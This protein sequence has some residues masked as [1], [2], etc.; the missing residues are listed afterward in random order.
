MKTLKFIPLG[1]CGEIGMNMAVL[2]VDDCNYFIDGGGLFPDASLPGVDLIIPETDWLRKNR[3]KPTAWLITHAHE[4][5]IGALPH[6]Y[7]EFPAPLYST[8][9][10]L[11]MIRS[12]FTEANI[13]GAS[14]QTW[15]VFNSKTIRNITVTPYTVNHS[16]PAST[17]LFIET[18]HGNILHT[19]DFRIDKNP[20]EGSLSHENMK[21]V[22]GQK[23]VRA[24]MSDS[25]NSFSK[26]TDLSEGDLGDNFDLIMRHT[27][28]AVVVTAF[29]SN[30]W[31][32]GTIV[33][34]AKKHDRKIFLLGRSM[35]KNF[36]ISQR[37]KIFDVRPDDVIGDDMLSR[38]PKNRLCIVCTG[39][40]G[41]GFSGASRLATDSIGQFKLEHGDTFVFS[42]R[43]I[44]GNE[45]S[46]GLLTNLIY[47]TG[48]NVVTPKDFNVHVSGH[49]FAED[50]KTCIQTVRPECFIPVHGEFRHLMRHRELAIECG[51]TE[52]NAYLVENG[53]V[54]VLGPQPQ[55]VTDRVRSG[56]EYISQGGRMSSD[57]EI[58]KTRMAL[59]KS[60]LMCVSFIIKKKAWEL[61]CEPN[62]IN[63]GVP[64]K[65]DVFRKK[66]RSV[67]ERSYAKASQRKDFKESML[68]EELR[69]QTR[70][71]L[72]NMV[73]Y[74]CN[75]AVLLQRV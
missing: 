34:T 44:P 42:A 37:L 24:M 13:R 47:R 41:E 69:I 53:D 70:Q 20:P 2:Q 68:E 9:F 67:F 61:V 49:G 71:T 31:R 52:K 25:T 56:R 5:H 62:F 63:K 6:L 21:R 74:K 60:G 10:S 28:G 72:E 66:L 19:G 45:K 27:D 16:I 65:E 14:L 7:P 15:E 43:A 17:G 8:E 3:I 11:E 58:F 33:E 75:V 55:G 54:C 26:G 73:N 18:P 57:G 36:E 22:I 46:I 4:D 48:A 40:Q 29:A 39:S 1:G 32:L 35:Q 50:L 59:C 23:K 12:K 64:V 51:V 30:I 38:I